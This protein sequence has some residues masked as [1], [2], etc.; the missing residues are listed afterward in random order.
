MIE[1]KKHRVVK[2]QLPTTVRHP[3]RQVQRHQVAVDTFVLA[4]LEIKE[5]GQKG[6]VKVCGDTI[7]R[8]TF[9][10]CATN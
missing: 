4:K 1:R 9:G 7:Q 10:C 8:D 5:W 6:G 3:F 2:G